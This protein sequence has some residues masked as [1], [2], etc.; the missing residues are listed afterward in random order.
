MKKFRI[1]YVNVLPVLVLA[2]LIFKLIDSA[3]LSMGG[4]WQ[5]LYG[6]VAYFIAGFFIAYLLNPAVNFFEAL[7][8]S[9]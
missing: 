6:C 5:A 1:P 4:L 9:Q 8:R 7:I 3:N 2:F